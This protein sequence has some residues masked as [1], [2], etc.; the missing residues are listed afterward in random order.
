LITSGCILRARAAASLSPH[1][2]GE[3]HRTLLAVGSVSVPGAC[4][5]RRFAAG[6]AVATE[7]PLPL[8]EAARQRTTLPSSERELPDTPCYSLDRGPA[9]FARRLSSLPRW[10]CFLS[11]SSALQHARASCAAPILARTNPSRPAMSVTT[12]GVTTTRMRRVR[13]LAL[14]ESSSRP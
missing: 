13:D 11:S 1:A 12:V 4:P 8:A 7:E 3:N 14:T 2:Y 9:C 6:C 5:R 10:D